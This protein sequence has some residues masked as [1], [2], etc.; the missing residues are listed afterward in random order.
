MNLFTFVSG[1]AKDAIVLYVCCM[2]IIVGIRR[3]VDLPH[4]GGT[5]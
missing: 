5:Q 4:H 1:I 2:Y 3:E